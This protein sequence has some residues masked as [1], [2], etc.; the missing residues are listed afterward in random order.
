[1]HFCIHAFYIRNKAHVHSCG[2]LIY[3]HV[4]DDDEMYMHVFED[5]VHIH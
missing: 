2:D 5:V 1:M 3:M 4:C